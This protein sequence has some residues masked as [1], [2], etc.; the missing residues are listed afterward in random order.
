MKYLTW[1]RPQISTIAA[2]VTCRHPKLLDHPSMA[3]VLGLPIMEGLP[4]LNVSE[5][6]AGRN[7][8]SKRPAPPTR[9]RGSSPGVPPP[10]PPPQLPPPASMFCPPHLSNRTNS[11]SNAYRP[12]PQDLDREEFEPHPKRVHH[13]V[14][15]GNHISVAPFRHDVNSTNTDAINHEPLNNQV[16]TLNI[17]AALNFSV[18]KE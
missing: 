2:T 5:H 8:S 7:G 18:S 15:Y 12:P 17:F 6:G 1:S 13:D 3:S 11:S 4:S 9:R 16:C 10:P 14:L